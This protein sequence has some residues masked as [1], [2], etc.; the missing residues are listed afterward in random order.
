M[1]I[2]SFMQDEIWHLFLSFVND[3]GTGV[4]LWILRNSYE[5]LFYRTPTGDCFY[6][7]QTIKQPWH[8]LSQQVDINWA[9]QKTNTCSKSTI[10]TLEEGVKYVNIS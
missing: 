1:N 4:F 3:S 6:K 7:W 2:I 9:T 5:H 8:K 10:E